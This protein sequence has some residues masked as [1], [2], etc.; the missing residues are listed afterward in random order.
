M[1]DIRDI[2]LKH[3]GKRKIDW[4]KRH[5]P[6]LNSIKKRF[7]EEKPFNGVRITVSVH[8]EAKTAYMAQVLAE[9]GAEVRAT[10]CN[11]LSTQDDVA[12][13]LADSGVETFGWHN[14]TESEYTDHLIKALSHCPHVFLD[15][16]GDLTQLLH[17][18][19]REMLPN[20]RGGTEETTTGIMRLKARQRAGSLRLPMIAVNDADCKHLFDNR[21]GTGQSVIDGIMRATNLILAG[22]NFVVAGYGYCGK[23]IAKRAAGM[24]ANVI[25][26][27]IDPVKAMEAVMEGFRVMTM[28]EASRIGEIFVT[29]TGCKDVI[30]AEHFN[31][32]RDEAVLCNAG[33][34]DV[35]IS[36]RDLNR[37]SKEQFKSRK[38]I[39]TYVME[40]G[41]KINLLA[42]G[43][44]VNLAAGDGHPAEIMDL[45]FAL[46]VLSLEYLSVNYRDLESRVYQVPEE[47]DT[48]V[49]LLR[50]ASWGVSIDA[51]SEEQKEYIGSWG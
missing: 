44:L 43:R 49:A 28:E 29:V 20:I 5:M 18:D 10:G 32:M 15:D 1:S 17:S 42:E 13:A 47:I 34:F 33:H 7:I 26:T 22:K 2:S 6:I 21:Y 9:G 50:L 24:G 3:E 37:L 27:E 19:L 51:L 38:D 46:Q 8:M 35:E 31:N 23:G 41:R 40:D 11:P 25:V 48:K 39:T 36:K 16:G 12:A 14:A 30:R 4:V 45:S